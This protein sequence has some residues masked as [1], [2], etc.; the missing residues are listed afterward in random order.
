MNYL[1]TTYRG[2]RYGV[3]G[4]THWLVGTHEKIRLHLVPTISEE[5]FH[6]VVDYH[7]ASHGE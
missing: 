2:F 6:A 4:E 5:I 3:D 1:Y 7:I